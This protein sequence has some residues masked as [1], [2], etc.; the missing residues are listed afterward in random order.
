MK[1]LESALKYMEIFYS[2]KDLERLKDILAE[3]LSFTGPLFKFNSAEDYIY[4]LIKDPPQGMKY[5]IIKTFE[6]DNS[7]CLIYKFYKGNISTTMAQIFE[8]KD[9][10]I[11]KINLIFDTKTFILNT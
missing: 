4:S 7:V 9:V 1:P 2:G 6:D 8:V 3:D 11:S 5:E 10:K